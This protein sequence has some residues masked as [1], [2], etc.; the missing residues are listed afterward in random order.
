ST[1]TGDDTLGLLDITVERNGWGP[2]SESF[3]GR[4]DLPWSPLEAL[5]VRAPRITRTGSEVD[6][7]ATCRGEPAIVREGRLWAATCHPE[8]LG[9][10]ALHE[11]VVA[12]C[13]GKVTV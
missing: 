12:A 5:F 9:N 6:T 4:C 8:A 11:G 13:K 10:A 7:L 1:T 3:K 2:Q